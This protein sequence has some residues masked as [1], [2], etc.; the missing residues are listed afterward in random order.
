MNDQPR[1]QGFLPFF[2]SLPPLPYI[3][4]ARSPGNEVVNERIFSLELSACQLR[5]EMVI[6]LVLEPR[7]VNN[8][9]KKDLLKIQNNDFKFS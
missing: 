5:R 8:Q 9:P 3:K 4:I 7:D 1:Y 2:I 6:S